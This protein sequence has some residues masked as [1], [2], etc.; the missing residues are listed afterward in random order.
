MYRSLL[1]GTLMTACLV[2]RA[3]HASID[4]PYASRP[5]RAGFDIMLGLGTGARLSWRF[6]NGPL[7][8]VDLRFG[9]AV[10][11]VVWE[12]PNPRA[13]SLGNVFDHYS[14][15]YLVQA[16][17]LRLWGPLAFELSGGFSRVGGEWGLLEDAFTLW[18]PPEPTYTG[19]TAGAALRWTPDSGSPL[20][21]NAGAL[22]LSDVCL[23]YPRLVIDVGPTFQW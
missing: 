8:S 13:L 17:D 1:F 15:A 20:T 12:G 6:E 2:P 21:V 7:R 23:H 22:L 11:A 14:A 18:G 3:A 4:L 16:V 9:Y 10:P 19:F 5:L